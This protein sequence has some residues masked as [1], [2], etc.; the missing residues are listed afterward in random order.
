MLVYLKFSLFSY[1]NVIKP[2]VDTD[3]SLLSAFLAAFVM[4]GLVVYPIIHSY[5]ALEYS[6][7]G[8]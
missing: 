6:K 7:M 4:G 1:L 5:W 8:K 3:L 2:R